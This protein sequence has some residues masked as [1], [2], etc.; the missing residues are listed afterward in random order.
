MIETLIPQR[1][2]G[3]YLALTRSHC[4]SLL[5][6][7][8]L[9]LAY[10]VLL[11]LVNHLRPDGAGVSNAAEAILRRM[12]ALIGAGGAATLL[13]LLIGMAGWLI[14]VELRRRPELWPPLPRIFGLMLLESAAWAYVLGK[15]VGCLTARLTLAANLAG[16]TLQL[17]VRPALSLP[18]QLVLSLGA[19]LFE[20]LLFRVMLVGGLT[21]LLLSLQRHPS[22]AAAFA[23]LGLDGR[24]RATLLAALLSALS[25]SLLHY[26]GPY[27]DAFTL[28]SFTFRFLAGLAF[29]GVYLVRG[30]GIV[31]WAHALY[32]L[33][34]LLLQGGGN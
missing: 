24:L 15:T 12:L 5:F 19:G 1:V 18:E 6:A 29:T 16:P 25:F 10:E 7:L 3:G 30:F 2:P 21:G 4:Y 22:V 26:V 14:R 27:R 32:D 28:P 9:L 20:E 23:W 13:L 31:A 17:T 34:V 8:P 11:L 33:G